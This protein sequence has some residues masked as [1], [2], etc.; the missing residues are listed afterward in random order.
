MA[1]L[2]CLKGILYNMKLRKL[3]LKDATLMIEW[4]HNEDIVGELKG[5]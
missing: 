3:E 5:C 4:M 1:I 2:I